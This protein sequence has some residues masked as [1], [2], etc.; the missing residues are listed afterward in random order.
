MNIGKLAFSNIRHNLKKYAVFFFA[1]W[2]CI[3]TTYTFLALTLS[4][5]VSNK[6]SDSSNYQSMFIGFGIAILIFTL[7]FLISS[8]NSFIRARKR[9]IS[10]YALFGM[11]NSKIG[12]MLFF[13]TLLLGLAAL[14]AA[15]LLGVFLSKLLTMILLKMVMSAYSGDIAFS[16]EPAAIIITCIMYLGIFAV[17]GLS[18][19]RLIS[20]FQL[21]DL[22]KGDKVSE[23]KSKGSY[24][25]LI[26]SVIL[27]LLGYFFAVSPSA[28][29]VVIMMLPIIVVVVVGT[30][31]FFLGGF[32]KIMHLIKRNK[33]S[34]YKKTKLISIS[35]LSHRSRTMA[36]MMA[37]I[38]ILVAIGTTAI[39]FGYTLFQNSESQAYDMSV[40]D[41][42]Y[43][44]DD[45]TLTEDVNAVFGKYGVDITDEIAFQRYESAPDFVNASDDFSGYTSPI[46]TYKESEYNRIASIAKSTLEQVSVDSGTALL[47]YKNYYQV[48]V[49]DNTKLVYGDSELS[50]DYFKTS[51]SSNFSYL[52]FVI[53]LD[54]ADFDNLMAAG[55]ITGYEN[56]SGT[57][58]TVTGINY[59]KALSNPEIAASLE[60]VL[61]SR[62]IHSQL[63]YYSYNEM[64][65]NFGLLCFIGFFMCTVFMLMTASMLYFKQITIA[66]EEK[67]QYAMLRKI[68]M[69][70]DEEN[71]V[72]RKRLLPIFFFPLL[73]G[74]L[75]SVFAMKG[76]DTLI[77]TN[78]VATSGNTFISVLK[79]SLVMYA[80]YTIVYTIFYF[81]TKA[82]YKQAVK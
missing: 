35:L 47:A 21:V 57:I 11:E 50:V 9:E 43:I 7:F 33:R 14:A 49:K 16:I 52:F 30:Y 63:V 19:R 48:A 28:G 18:G 78:M 5:S 80:A 37:T 44:S 34:Y 12:R 41:M 20:R 62:A 39:A 59:D 68:G 26:L 3:F 29:V 56:D 4:E 82:Q 13:E 60:E 36:T 66:T 45:D 61:E 24:F 70:A 64:L 40:F 79:T 22:F 51:S 81:I 23:G 77:F 54:D 75:H 38:A 71:A 46:V 31:L 53:V 65:S 8:N 6:L 42:Y 32:Q 72:V 76:A 15:I 27:I 25:M 17:M 74:I 1:M 58:S 55:K 10:T 2:F 73:M 67:K 69:S